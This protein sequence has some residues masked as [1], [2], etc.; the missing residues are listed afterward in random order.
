MS[1]II[2][3]YQLIENLSNSKSGFSK[4]GFAEKNG[5]QVFIKEFLSP[6]YPENDSPIYSEQL[7][8]KRQIC[9]E[10]E[11]RKKKLY[12]AIKNSSTGNIITIKEIFRWK[13]KY[14]VVTEKV[15]VKNFN[16]NIIAG[17]SKGQKLLLLKIVTYC[18]NSLHKNGV[19]H[20]DIK[21]DNILIKE[22]QKG[23]Y[24]AK[25]IDFD[26]SFFGYDIPKADEDFNGDLVYLAPES[27]WYITGQ[28]KSISSKIDVY[29]LGILFHQYFT[30]RVPYFDA[31]KYNYAFEAS[32][33]GVELE[34]DSYIPIK[35]SNLIK[36]MINIYP[37]SRP[38]LDDVFLKLSAGNILDGIISEIPPNP[39]PI[40]PFDNN[41]KAGSNVENYFK[42]ADE[43][44]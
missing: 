8:T 42:K 24:T 2:N 36:E 38:T 21:F 7:Q 17:M 43:L 29:A 16:L 37:E 9:Y 25:L 41:F 22:T 28:I 35:I 12:S 30:G 4:W 34:I 10:F 20:G 1:D 39:I 19:V 13:T 18:V 6:V 40:R 14:Y 44:W 11:D 15:D 23:Y 31:S 5:E 26:S 32:L 3:G 33:D 27:F